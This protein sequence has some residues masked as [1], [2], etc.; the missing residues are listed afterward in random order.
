[1][2]ELSSIEAISS[3]SIRVTWRLMGTSSV[4]VFVEGFYVR[5][6]AMSGGSQQTFNMKTVM[7]SEGDTS[8]VIGGLLKFTEYEVFLQPFFRR[9]EGQPSNSLH[10][11]TLEDA[12]SAPPAATH[13]QMVRDNAVEIRWA[14]PPPQHR[15][16]VLLGYQVR[17]S[18]LRT[19]VYS[20]S[21]IDIL[22]KSLWNKGLYA[23]RVGRYC[24][25][26]W[27]QCLFC[28][29]SRVILSCYR[30]TVSIHPAIS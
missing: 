21:I 3:T 27:G 16:G 28:Q 22:E 4:A 8:Y 30:Q 14:P 17:Q 1:M 5:F 18:L 20:G 9:V 11:Q 7:R 26:Y 23:P 10:V 13:V 24:G 2:V 29:Q 6:R 25:H 15:N 12:P 19:L